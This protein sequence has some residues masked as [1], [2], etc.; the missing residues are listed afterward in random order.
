[1]KL[2]NR[3]LCLIGRHKYGKRNRIENIPW[4]SSVF[5]EECDYCGYWRKYGTDDGG[6][7]WMSNSSG[8]FKFLRSNKDL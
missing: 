6:N 8:G 1:M 5:K 3:I 2:L 4:H 7:E